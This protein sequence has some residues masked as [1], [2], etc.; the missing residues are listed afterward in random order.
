MFTI[1]A[2][3]IQNLYPCPGASYRHQKTLNLGFHTV[4]LCFTSCLPSGFMWIFL[5]T[6]SL[7]KTKSSRMASCTAVRV[8][9]EEHSDKSEKPSKVCPPGNL[10]GT[11]T[12]QTLSG[13]L[14]VPEATATRAFEL[15]PFV[16]CITAEPLPHEERETHTLPSHFQSQRVVNHTHQLS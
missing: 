14:Q 1:E 9:L 3:A 11:S 6:I 7:G 8:R 2:L 12:S 16:S 10:Q 5:P 15:R 13:R 4:L